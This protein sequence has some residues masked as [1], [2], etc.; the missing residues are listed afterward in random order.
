MYRS[1][2]VTLR[3]CVIVLILYSATLSAREIY[4]RSSGDYCWKVTSKSGETDVSL[5]WI[6]FKRKRERETEETRE[7]NIKAIRWYITLI[8]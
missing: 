6:H 7:I 3:I 4:L 5:T 2:P 8:K 1:G